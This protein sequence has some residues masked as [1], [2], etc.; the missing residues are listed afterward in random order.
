MANWDI[1]TYY[2]AISMLIF[3]YLLG[4]IASA[5]WIGKRYYGIDI[6]EQESRYTC[7]YP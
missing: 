5:V 2:C 1:M 3:A 4:S 6:R 7:V